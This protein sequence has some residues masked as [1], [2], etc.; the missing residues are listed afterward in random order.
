MHGRK[1]FRVS[2]GL[3]FAAKAAS[4]ALLFS[5]FAMSQATWVFPRFSITSPAWGTYSG[6]IQHTGIS[7]YK[8]GPLNQV[9]WSFDI[10]PNN[11]ASGGAD[12]FAHYGAPLITMANTVIV[13]RTNDAAGQTFTFFGLNGTTGSTLWSY[14][15][16]YA[17]CFAGPGGW[18]AIVEGS[19]VLRSSYAMPGKAGKV[20]LRRYADQATSATDTFTFYGASNYAAASAWC[21]NYIRICTPITGDSR[22]NFWFGY[23]VSDAGGNYAAPP[24]GFTPDLGHGGLVRMNS[25]GSATFIKAESMVPADAN[26]HLVANNCAPAISN[27][28]GSVYVALCY[29]YYDH[30]GYLVKLNSSTLAPQAS[31][32]F[33][34]PATG[35]NAGA[36]HESSA[37]PTVGPDGDVYF[38]VFGLGGGAS[39]RESHG[40][41]LHFD[42]NLVQKGAQGGFGWDDTATI[43]PAS[44]VKSYTGTSSYLILTKFN[45]YKW[46]DFWYPGSSGIDYGADGLNAVAIEDPNDASY[47]DRL[48]SYYGTP[49]NV[50]KPA[51]LVYGITPDDTVY[52]PGSVREWCINS[53]AVDP[54]TRSIVINSEDGHVYRWD[55]DSNSLQPVVGSNTGFY[56]NAPIGE[57]YTSTVIGPDGQMYAINDHK[58]YCVGP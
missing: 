11:P 10:D 29:G 30:R 42:S 39:Y 36:I 24:A 8:L 7:R 18:N 45:N 50:M 35:S 6:N 46:T 21:D 22:G 20:Y 33:K 38:G 57:A 5:A 31:V 48:S 43:V 15:T 34:S 13:P 16:D 54:A 40:W 55:L 41:M 32:Y 3:S 37:T 25:T 26:T 12:I 58:V 4:S 56:L 51:A 19:I 2:P 23:T 52:V 49:Y 17:P 27:D 1:S 14:N 9:E 28:L 47:S 44:M 53:A